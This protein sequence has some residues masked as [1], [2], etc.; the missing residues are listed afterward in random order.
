MNDIKS[1]ALGVAPSILAVAKAPAHKGALLSL[2]AACLFVGMAVKAAD[3]PAALPGARAG[4]LAAQQQQI[5]QNPLPTDLVP[6][7]LSEVPRT[8]TSLFSLTYW[9]FWP[10][11]PASCASTYAG[12]DLYLSLSRNALFVDD[13]QSEALALAIAAATPPIPGGIGNYGTNGGTGTNYGPMIDS[14]PTIRIYT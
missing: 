12:S 6:V 2:A 10:P 13:R 1:V 5:T 11:L 4:I 14:Q 7:Q 9:P 3:A 8:V